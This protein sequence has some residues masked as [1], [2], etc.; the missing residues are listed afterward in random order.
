MSRG[1]CPWWGLHSWGGAWWGC[2]QWGGDQWGCARWMVPCWIVLRCIDMT[3]DWCVL[4]CIALLDIS[5]MHV[6]PRGSGTG[7]RYSW[8]V[9]YTKQHAAALHSFHCG[10][11]VYSLHWSGVCG[12][13]WWGVGISRAVPTLCWPVYAVPSRL[14]SALEG[15]RNSLTPNLIADSSRSHQAQKVSLRLSMR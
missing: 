2:R 14:G 1:R 4:N 15:A 3:H 10:H 9:R 13:G 6:V 5:H 8:S 7:V 12:G 11:T